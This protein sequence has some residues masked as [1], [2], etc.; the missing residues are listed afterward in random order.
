MSEIELG[1]TVALPMRPYARL[2]TMLGDQ[3]ISSGRIA[4]VELVKNSYDADAPWVRVMFKGI[5]DR[6]NQSIVIEDSGLGMSEDVITQQ[7]LNPA[8]PSKWLKKTQGNGNTPSGRHMQGEK[9]IG[10]FAILKLARKITIVTRA[11]ALDYEMVLDY[12]FSEY[13]DDF[14]RATDTFLDDLRV[15]V[16]KRRP[17]V[18]VQGRTV[19]IGKCSIDAPEYGTQ[20]SLSN[21]KSIWTESRI[22]EVGHD[23][24]YLQPV[25]SPP[26]ENV[27]SYDDPAKGFHVSFYRDGVELN[28][29][30][31]YLK[32]LRTLLEE[33]SVVRV[34][35]GR[36]DAD[37]KEF[38]YCQ[39]GRMNKVLPLN[40][41]RI[42][43][44]YLWKRRVG[45]DGAL[46]AWTPSCGSFGFQFY[47]FDFSS[48]SEGK[49]ALDKKNKEIIK[50]HR[51]YLYRDG[52]RVYPYG[53]DTDDWLSI[54]VMRGTISAG[55]FLSNAQIVGCVDITQKENPHLRDKT[56]REGLIEEGDAKKDFVFCLQ[57]FLSYIKNEAFK[58]YIDSTKE[59]RVVAAKAKREIEQ[60]IGEARQAILDGSKNKAQKAL[61]EIESLYKTESEHIDRRL[62]TTESL[63]GVGMSV[64]TA[65]HDLMSMMSKVMINLDGLLR[66]LMS[67]SPLERNALIDELNKMSG[68][69]SFVERQMRDIQ[70]LFVSSKQRR[71]LIEVKPIVEKVASI[72]ARLLKKR[73]I[74]F[75]L[76]EPR[77]AP[78]LKAKT[79]DAVLLQLLINLFDNAAYW[80]SVV[81]AKDKRIE[82]FLDGDN[83]RLIFSDN[84]PGVKK[85]DRDYIFEP[86]WS[87]KG[88]DGRGLGLYIARQLLERHD[89]AIDLGE[90]RSECRLKGANFVVSFVGEKGC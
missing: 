9:G 63:A 57:L 38:S 14:N 86:F 7:W 60:K 27:V 80:L 78:P 11:K 69:L 47:I 65:S 41:E 6:T 33:S 85:E 81:A 82:V 89:Y 35:N 67:G 17:E 42:K 59:K 71:R 87:G 75:I 53:E 74:S 66:D 15:K 3:L 8:S 37:R 90:T 12:D 68:Q 4:L 50:R 1:E 58:V 49:Y 2:L 40:D 16:K 39:D 10:R 46:D 88:E 77:H 70:L 24:A 13:G 25:F 21:L 62:Q 22:D 36:Y 19:N 28:I 55:M 54:D 73:G 83:C 23:I 29:E 45:K 64:E 52:I 43:G 18:F 76:S 44:T 72:Y 48:N 84:G 34:T 56:N 30:G 20:I 51:I 26:L 5:A 31:E 79:T 61:S 32:D